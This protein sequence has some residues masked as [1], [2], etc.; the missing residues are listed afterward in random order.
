MWEIIDNFT[1]RLKV[2]G[3]WIVRYHHSIE[4]IILKSVGIGV[5]MIFIS[6]TDHCWKLT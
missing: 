1:E 2:P 3:G 5:A 6:D 4:D